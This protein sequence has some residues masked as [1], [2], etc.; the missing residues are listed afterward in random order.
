MVAKI[1][2][3]SLVSKDHN[4][5]WVNFRSFKSHLNFTKK[6]QKLFIFGTFLGHFQ[7]VLDHFHPLQKYIKRI[8]FRFI[9][10]IGSISTFLYSYF[11]LRVQFWMAV[12]NLIGILQ[13]VKLSKRSSDLLHIALRPEIGTRFFS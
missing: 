9:F 2:K 8:K 10:Q 11:D 1:A 4:V 13:L 3:T 5:F 12:G 7:F 6:C